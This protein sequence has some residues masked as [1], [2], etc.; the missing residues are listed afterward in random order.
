[1]NGIMIVKRRFTEDTLL[2]LYESLNMNGFML[3]TRADEDGEEQAAEMAS[4]L[5]R[6]KIDWPAQYG[7]L[8]SPF[9]VTDAPPDRH[10][11]QPWPTGR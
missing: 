5:A 6:A 3:V 1:M 9:S 7:Y 8:Y 10:P 4:A 2:F 11:E